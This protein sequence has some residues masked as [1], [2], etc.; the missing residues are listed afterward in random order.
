MPKKK[1]GSILNKMNQYFF[2][3]DDR[4]Q[5]DPTPPTRQAVRKPMNNKDVQETKAKVIHKYPKNGEFRFPLEMDE[6]PVKREM[7]IRSERREAPTQKQYRKERDSTRRKEQNEQKDVPKKQYFNNPHFSVQNIPSPVY[8]FT[9]DRTYKSEPPEPSEE[10]TLSNLSQKLAG[11]VPPPAMEMEKSVPVQQEVDEPMD[12]GVSIE[13]PFGDENAEEA[14]ETDEP[15]VTEPTPLE[16]ESLQP[17]E[18]VAR[19]EGHRQEEVAATAALDRAEED[20][21]EMKRQEHSKKRRSFAKRPEP[22]KQSSLVP[23]NVMMTPADRAR[24]MNRPAY[25]RK[26]E[27]MKEKPI[28]DQAV[29]QPAATTESRDV[30]LPPVSLLSEP[31]PR[32]E[33]SEN[34]LAAQREQLE[35]TLKHFHVDA[36]VTD[37]TEGPSVVRFEVQP[38]PGVKVNKVTNLTDDLKLAMA[39][40]DLRM[41]APIPGK[42]AIG[43]EVPKQ[44]RSPVVLREILQ[45]EEFRQ[46]PSPLAVALGLDITGHPSVIDLN[47][48]PHGLIAGSTGSGKSV[49][50]NSILLSLLYKSSPDEVKLLLIDPKVVELAFYENIPHLA[51][52]VVTDPKEATM[53]LKW[54]VQE[55]ERRYQLFASAGVRD[56]KGYNRKEDKEEH[57]PYLVIVIDEL[58][59][60]MMIAPQDVEE[61]ICRIAQKARA[62]G[63]HLLVATQRP[64]VDVITGLIK[65]NI[66]TR[67]AFAVS[68]MADSRTILDAGGAERLIGR[69][70]MLF[71]EN[72][73][74][75]FVRLQGTYVADEEIE[76]VTAYWKDRAKP[77]YLFNKEELV[78][79][80][81]AHH[82]SDEL[83]EEVSYFVVHQG[84]AS[85]SMIQRRYHIGYNRA[86]RLMDMLEERGIVS[87]AVGTKP[88]HVLV[89]EES[90]EEIYG[91]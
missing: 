45:T 28:E 3:N 30:T 22:K 33:G 44:N 75:R 60:L 41:E 68:S 66:P 72:G 14:T 73:A 11:D 53:T 10:L 82:S 17:M 78:K 8:G 18:P 37:V 54:S 90:L 61:S 24:Q 6:R 9:R 49:C 38:A 25:E 36:R 5:K 39:A 80:E 4:K 81:P 56:I 26:K 88:R 1:F 64:S 23:F 20:Q 27:A 29:H 19:E 77:E 69:G 2:G 52:P 74:S 84:S 48:M 59:D 15:V 79:Q 85:T 70:D 91:A 12:E 7:P 63:I 86:A 47:A 51:A 50:I 32:L 35:A 21:E 83:L 57:L 42:N 13:Q 87:E 71:S 43:I 46:H 65:A 40:I 16:E 31:E 55:M 67:A 76:R 62:C 58:A 34:D 89:S